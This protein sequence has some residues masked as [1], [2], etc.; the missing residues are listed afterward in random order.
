MGIIVNK[1][2]TMK[3][4]NLFILI[5]IALFISSGVVV[6]QTKSTNI[7]TINGKSYVF[8]TIEKGQSLYSISKL[9]NVSLD[10]IYN[11]NP[12]TKQG[13]KAGQEI[14]LP[15]VVD[16]KQNV[17]V[18]NTQVSTSNHADVID[19]SLYNYHK[20]LKGET[21]YSI[22]RKYNKTEKELVAINPNFNSNI[23]EGQLIL[24]D[25]K[26][27][28]TF[29]KTAISSTLNI[30]G[31]AI[32]TVNL[33][34]NTS[35]QIKNKETKN[36]YNIAL[37]LPFKFNSTLGL[38]LNEMVKN[39]SSFPVLPSLSTDFY[40]GFK[41]AIDSL[42]ANNFEINLELFDIDEKDSSEIQNLINSSNFKNFD[43]I[44][45][46]LHSNSF[47]T[48]SLKAKEYNIPIISPLAQQ[49]KILY[50]N[51]YA[52]K[53]NPTHYALLESLADYIIDS[54]KVNTANVMLVAPFEKDAK[55]IAYCKYFKQYYADKIK[56]TG[57]T[58]KDS[59]TNVRGI[60][61]AKQYYKSD[62]KNIFVSL[63]SNQVFLADFTT[64]LAIFADKKDISLCGWQNTS[65]M[66]NVD[67]EYL[68]QLN[69]FFPHQYNITNTNVYANIVDYYRT[70]Q[71][72][73]PTENF[74]I[75]FDL[76]MFYLKNL[77]EKGPNFIYDLNNYNS[78]LNYTRYKFS[79]PDAQTGFDNTGV[80]IFKYNNYQLIKTGWK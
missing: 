60:A 15:F 59:L 16:N 44:F 5:F 29:V 14:K 19:T 32:N 3:F 71:N 72:V 79:H 27:K 36:T 41:R 65:E 66:E 38:D 61:G 18:L 76:A 53:T 48:V 17:N 34:N 1:L 12:E 50:N 55:E 39:K 47:K 35:T 22:L 26:P 73:N 28:K 40:I 45:G 33:S 11:L 56:S 10:E 24:L 54:I 31:T 43:M 20:V 42:T 80:F 51:I 75:G 70:L 13:T 49:N 69:Y 7:Q 25:K 68:N 8:H 46:P 64:Q 4:K 67:Q 21:L 37:I 9:Y 6:A 63:S 78:E 52:S 2:V 23:K 58:I 62:V 30:T 57:K 74:Y 77:K